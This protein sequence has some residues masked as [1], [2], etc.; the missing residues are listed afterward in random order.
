MT[1]NTDWDVI[2]TYNIDMVEEPFFFFFF[3]TSNLPPRY[4]MMAIAH[5]QNGGTALLLLGVLRR[6]TTKIPLP[7]GQQ[8]LLRSFRHSGMQ[9]QPSIFLLMKQFWRRHGSLFAA[10]Y[11]VLLI[12][13]ARTTGHTIG[14]S[15]LESFTNRDWKRRHCF[16]GLDDMGEYK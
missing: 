2:G 14:L 6:G 16:C 13:L 7:Y 12:A 11:L 10:D 5:C 4:L 9:A 8:C 1:T 3:W 15:A